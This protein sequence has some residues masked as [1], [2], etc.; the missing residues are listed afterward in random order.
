MIEKDG[1][2]KN[3]WIGRKTG[4]HDRYFAR[5]KSK[6]MPIRFS[7]KKTPAEIMSI[8][9][10]AGTTVS[11]RDGRTISA[12]ASRRTMQA[13]GRSI[14]GEEDRCIWY[15]WRFFLQR[16]SDET[17][18]CDQAIVRSEEKRTHRRETCKVLHRYGEN[19]PG[20]RKNN[21]I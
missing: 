13:G 1:I 20:Q 6:K 10:S 16:R 12:S 21:G 14:P 3:F 5:K 19:R 15:I 4:S 7:T 17:R 2:E 11:T 9:S 18:G 8:Y